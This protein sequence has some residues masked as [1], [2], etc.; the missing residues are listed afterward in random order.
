MNAS[1]LTQDE[2]VNAG[3]TLTRPEAESLQGGGRGKRRAANKK[4]DGWFRVR[5]RVLAVLTSR[6]D[7]SRRWTWRKSGPE[8]NW[9]WQLVTSRGAV[10]NVRLNRGAWL[11]EVNDETEKP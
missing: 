9:H 4:N 11:Q 7:P 2:P 8:E 1:V 6:E 10:Y 5:F 3:A